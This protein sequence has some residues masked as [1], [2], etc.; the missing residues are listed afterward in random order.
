LTVKFKETLPFI[1]NNLDLIGFRVYVDPNP[2]LTID[3]DEI[4]AI[5]KIKFMSHV[6]YLMVAIY[7]SNLFNKRKDEEKGEQ[8]YDAK[9]LFEV[10]KESS[11]I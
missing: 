7:L 4:A 5:L 9:D 10:V 8:L 2:A 3:K 11:D 1:Y 6:A